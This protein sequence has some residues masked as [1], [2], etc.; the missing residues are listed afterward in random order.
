MSGLPAIYDLE[1]FTGV[2][3][4]WYQFS[5]PDDF[6]GHE[7]KP[8]GRIIVPYGDIQGHYLV[9]G[10]DLEFGECG[11]IVS[12]GEVYVA[13]MVNLCPP[14]NL[15][16]KQLQGYLWLQKID[17]RFLHIELVQ[18]SCKKILISFVEDYHQF[19]GSDM[20]SNSEFFLLHPIPIQSTEFGCQYEYSVKE[21]FGI[22]GSFYCDQY[23]TKMIQ[24][25]YVFILD[26]RVEYEFNILPYA[27]AIKKMRLTWK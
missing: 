14:Q 1:T 26:N 12:L 16:T 11:D 15:G 21:Q 3:T 10:L 25:P 5:N 27:S 23:V 9:I 7:Y 17:L 2:W 13:F 6:S 22:L 4:N 18:G 8:T 19:Y 24:D 20:E